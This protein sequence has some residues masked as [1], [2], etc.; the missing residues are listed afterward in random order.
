VLRFLVS[1]R[2]L[3]LHSGM[4]VC[5]IAFGFLAVWQ[6]DRA[7]TEVVDPTTL[8]RASV[9]DVAAPAPQIPP[10][11]AGRLVEA[12]GRYVANQRFFIAD[13]THQ[14]GQGYWVMVPLALED[15][16]I[17][18]VVRGFVAERSDPAAVTPRGAIRVE[19]VLQPSEDL[20]RIPLSAEDG[21]DDDVLSGVATSELVAFV[22]GPLL[23]G[24]IAATD[25]QP[26]PELAPERLTAD[27]L[28]PTSNGLKVQN[29]A[30][31]I[32]WTVFALFVV[33]V[34][35]KFMLDARADYDQRRAA[36]ASPPLEES[37]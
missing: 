25:E 3:A 7:H 30:Y 5:V 8:A 17:V 12:E 23:P 35:R 14:G 37:V 6:W 31:T 22:E 36:A 28:A 1:P 16:T 4:V 11:A 27:D 33:F 34:Y 18:P 24:W 26:D 15:G 13:R 10:G 32:Q 20:A 19:G 9:I 2:A 29:V 21:P